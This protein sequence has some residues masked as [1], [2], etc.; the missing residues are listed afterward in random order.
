M[1]Q[2]F[3]FL[4][5]FSIIIPISLGDDLNELV[6]TLVDK[7]LLGLDFSETKRVCVFEFTNFTPR[8]PYFL[9]NIYQI[10]IATLERKLKERANI[11]DEV[12]GFDENSG[13]FNLSEE[14]KYDYLLSLTFSESRNRAIL[15]L[16]VFDGKEPE[17]LV[18]FFYSSSP[19]NPLEIDL[20]ERPISRHLSFIS[21]LYEPVY[22]PFK[23]L[24]LKFIDANKIAFLTE[25]KILIYEV[26]GEKLKFIEEINLNWEKPFYP[27]QDIT[28]R[29]WVENI[30]ENIYIFAGSSISS[31]VLVFT[32]KE[33]QW[34]SEIP[35][36]YIPSGKINI[37]KKSFLLGIKPKLGMNFF[38][39]LI[40]L[41]EPSSIVSENSSEILKELKIPPFYEILP[42]SDKDG[43]F[44]GIYLIDER[45]TLRFLNRNFRE[46]KI[47]EIKI[48]DRM[49]S[50][51]NYLLCTKFGREDKDSLLFLSKKDRHVLQETEVEGKI[52]SITYNSS[53][54]LGVL[55][56]DRNGDDLLYLWRKR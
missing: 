15:S 28:G 22:I 46:V 16:K 7:L 41:I 4:I 21:P 45:R 2:F 38:K 43:L 56:K 42:V 24:D 27:S 5:L 47:P 6:S 35:I 14:K 11:E 39:G 8:S 30:N 26:E 36:K 20:I 25:K 32:K 51:D 19:L 34:V 54:K 53:D 44:F 13:Y 50:I 1:K 23:A 49:I 40:A 9:Q 12:I 33:K 10:F 37:G 29:I 31:S 48:G 55:I 17:K 3:I 18:G 52:Y